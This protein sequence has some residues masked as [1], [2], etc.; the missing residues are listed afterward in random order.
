MCAPVSEVLNQKKC[1]KAGDRSRGTR[2][3]S[4]KSSNVGIIIRK[5]VAVNQVICD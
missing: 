2:A 1:K 4:R 3:M 5:A